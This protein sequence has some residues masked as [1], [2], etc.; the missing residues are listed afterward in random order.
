MYTPGFA[1]PE[2]YGN[3]KFLGPW[4]DIYSIGATMY[5]CL[6]GTTPQPADER[7]KHDQLIPATVCWEDQFSEQLLSTIDRCL[8]LNYLD[9][10]QSAFTLQ[11][12]LVNGDALSENPRQKHWLRRL[13]HKFGIGKRT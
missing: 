5:A 3:R 9:R 1:S 4:S 12:R 13:I 6:S 11:K 8:D 2:H 7:L 10:I